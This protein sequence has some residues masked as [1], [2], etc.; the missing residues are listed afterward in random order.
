MM[1]LN[2]AAVDLTRL[3][4]LTAFEL[5]VLFLVMD[6]FTLVKDPN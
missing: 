6:H 3:S 4:R 1:C 5:Q 2:Y